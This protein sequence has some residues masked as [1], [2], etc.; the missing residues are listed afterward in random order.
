MFVTK[1]MIDITGN[2]DAGNFASPEEIPVLFDL[3]RFI[4]ADRLQ[5][6]AIGNETV[7]NVVAPTNRAALSVVTARNP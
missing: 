3:E 2:V 5:D 4:P 7:A 1:R 6:V